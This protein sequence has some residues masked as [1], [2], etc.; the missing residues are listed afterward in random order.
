MPLLRTGFAGTPQTA[1]QLEQHQDERNTQH[2]QHDQCFRIPEV[3]A[4]MS[5]EGIVADEEEQAASQK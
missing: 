3:P 5:E 1:H 4:A 2:A